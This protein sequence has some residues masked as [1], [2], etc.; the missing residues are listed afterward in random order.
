MLLWDTG[1]V[2]R[3]PG[4]SLTVW[5]RAHTGRHRAL[6]FAVWQD[7]AIGPFERVAD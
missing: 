6:H 7:V 2:D 1:V 5:W 3:Q 4:Q